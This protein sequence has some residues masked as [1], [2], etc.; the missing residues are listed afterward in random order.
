MAKGPGKL[1][2]VH[3]AANGGIHRPTD[4]FSVD[5]GH[6]NADCAVCSFWCEVEAHLTASCIATFMVLNLALGLR[7]AHLDRCHGTSQ[8]WSSHRI[9][10]IRTIL[11]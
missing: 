6:F 9:F 3:W 2:I 4:V 8:N 10:G 7:R 5:P 1:Q 11:G